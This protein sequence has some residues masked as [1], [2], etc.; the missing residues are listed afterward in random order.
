MKDAIS[1]NQHA[2]RVVERVAQRNLRHLTCGEVALE[3]GDLARMH[4][5]EHREIGEMAL[6]ER[7]HRRRMRVLDRAKGRACRLV[8]RRLLC[9]RRCRRRRRCVSHLKLELERR[10]LRPV[11]ADLRADLRMQRFQLGRVVHRW[12]LGALRLELVAHL[13]REALNLRREAIK[14]HQAA[15]SSTAFSACTSALA[16]C[17]KRQ[18]GGN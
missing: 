1:G 13:M 4:L 7:R 14:G 11:R 8:R 17:V 9:R 2:I 12:R 5:L 18:S 3:L 16:A 10:D 6:L 15:S